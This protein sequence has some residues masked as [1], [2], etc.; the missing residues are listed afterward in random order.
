MR[1]NPLGRRIPSHWELAPLKYVTRSTSGGTP[2]KSNSEYWDG[3][4]PWISSED[5]RTQSVSDPE[6]YITSKG[7]EESSATL[8]PANSILIVSR[9]GILRHTIPVE[10]N[11]KPVAIN[12][13]ILALIPTSDEFIPEYIKYLINGHNDLLLNLWRS[14][15]ATVESIDT[16]RLKTTKIPLPAVEDQEW[17]VKTLDSVTAKIDRIIE[18]KEEAINLLNKRGN[19]LIENLLN[20]VSESD[21]A[22]I[23]Y[24]TDTLPGYAFPSDDFTSD[25]EDIPLLRGTNIGVGEIRWEDVA[26][27][28]RNKT[29]DYERYLL[30]PGDII[31]GM[32]R[33]WIKSGIR[34]ARMSESDCPSLLVQRV[35]R[36]RAKPSVDQEYIR[37]ALESERFKQYFEPITTGV[38]VP[39]I[40]ESQVTGFEVPLPDV[41]RQKEI[42]NIWRES[43]SSSDRLINKINTSIDFHEEF[44][45]SLISEVVTGQFDVTGA[46]T[47]ELES[48]T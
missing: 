12:Q 46:K 21:T 37:M 48:T 9:S 35:L 38:S 32:D 40:S 3:D 24:I 43:R 15:G 1:F 34:V 31:L 25:P 4:I 16:Q 30:E 44:K 23:K 5:V 17:I 10:V 19:A 13:D 27:W 33:P 20:E 14:R 28:P 45:H 22:K 26:Y 6:E 8:V 7:L 2:S 42:S 36:I 39:H 41:D 29:E 18:K 47:P 11:D